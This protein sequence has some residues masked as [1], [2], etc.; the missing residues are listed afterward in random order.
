[1]ETLILKY[2][3]KTVVNALMKS[4]TSHQRQILDPLCCAIRLALL[5]FKEKGTKISIANNKIHY[6]APNL[7]QGP[8]R[9]SQGDNRNDL[10]NLCNPIERAV[11]WYKPRNDPNIMNIFQYAIKGL[12]KLKQSYINQDE[13][14]GDSNL[15]CHSINHYIN[16]LENSI[17]NS[18]DVDDINDTSELRELWTNMEIMIVNSLLE[19]SENKLQKSDRF[20]YAIKAIEAILEGKDNEVQRLVIKFSTSI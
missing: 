8:V 13:K 9:W 5:Y 15:V 19:V 4:D 20:S 11:Q 18:V 10:H 17:N 6:Q 1:M 14:I 16:I 7:F 12:M 2:G 3:S